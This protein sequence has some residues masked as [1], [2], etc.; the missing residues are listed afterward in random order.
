MICAVGEQQG[1][2]SNALDIGSVR[3]EQSEL[4]RTNGED[5][6]VA[7]LQN[8]GKPPMPLEPQL[9]E[10]HPLLRGGHPPYQQGLG[11]VKVL[12]QLTWNP[13][14]PEP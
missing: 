2:E 13:C 1:K 12:H 9:H 14:E 3:L 10:A 8:L 6:G 11:R 7:S 4:E 5:Q